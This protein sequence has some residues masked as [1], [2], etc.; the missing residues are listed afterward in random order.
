VLQCVAVCC[1]MLQC[2]SHTRR[3]T[4]NQVVGYTRW[5]QCVAVCCS[6]LQCFAVLCSACAYAVQRVSTSE[7]FEREVSYHVFELIQSHLPHMVSRS[8][9]AVSCPSFGALLELA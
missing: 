1:S 4:G 5:L 6:V 3:D 8:V 7:K 2:V 9:F